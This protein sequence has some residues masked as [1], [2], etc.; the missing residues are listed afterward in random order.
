[1]F[2][3]HLTSRLLLGVAVSTLIL[4]SA[5]NVAMAEDYTN[6]TIS[7]VVQNEAGQA[8]AGATITV[9]NK[10]GTKRTIVTKV[11]GSYR[12]PALAIG[13][14]TATITKEGYDELNEQ[15]F[16]VT[17]G[18]S[19]QITFTLN[20]HNADMEEIFVVGTRQ[21][22][23]DFNT[24]TTGLTVSVDDLFEKTPIART[25]TAIALLAPGTT[26]G[27][28]AFG[29]LASIAGSSVAEN[30]YYIN[31]MNITNFRT[32]VGGSTLPFEFYDQIEVKTGGY[33]AEFGRSTGG[34]INAVTKSGSNEFHAGANVFWEG[35]AFSETRPDTYSN[36]NRFDERSNLNAN[37][38]LSGP[39]V[40]DKF[41]F[42]GMYNPRNNSQVDYTESRKF[43][44]K[45]NDPFWGLKL[46][47]IPIE[48]HHFEATFFSDDRSNTTESYKFNDLGK[49]IA[50]VDPQKDLGNLI[51]TQTDKLGG[52][53]KI[54]K[55]TGVITDWFTISALYGEN[56]YSRSSTSDTD[57]NPV[58]YSRPGFQGASSWRRLGNWSN[59]NVE[60]G[61]DLRKAYRVDA[62]L[63]F[64]ALGSHH[65]R[66]GWDREN[67][68]AI[69][70]SVNSGGVY[71]MY[72]TAGASNTQ[73][74]ADGQDYVRVREFRN[75]GTFNTI[76]SAVYAQD[77]W[78]VLDG[79]TLNA[80]IRNET[81]KN[82][83]GNGE[84]YIE[85]KNQIAWRLGFTWDP[86]GDGASRVYGNW[87]RY[88]LPIATNTSIRQA[89]AETYIQR[90]FPLDGLNPD[91]TPIYDAGAT[92]TFVEV[93][94]DGTISAPVEI[95][96]TNIKPMYQDEFI[97]G[98]EHDFQNGW[99]VGVRGI[100]RKLGRMIEDVAID[101]AVIKWAAENGYDDAQV[102]GT[103]GGFHQY[104][105]TNPGADMTVS[106]DK[107]GLTGL[108]SD[109]GQF[110]VA[111]LT[112]AQLGYPKGN[113]SYKAIELTFAREWD[114]LWSM[115]GSYTLSFSK[116]NTEG[117]VKSD[118]GQD[119]AGITTDFDQPGLVDGSFGYL[120]NDRRHKFKLWGAY[121]ATDWMTVGVNLSLTSPRK[122]G[123][124][125]FHPTDVFAQAYG[126]NS[127][128]CN[129]VLTPRAQSFSTGWIKKLDLSASIT[130]GF[131]DAIPGDVVLRVD[132]FNVFNT[133]GATDYNEIGEI[134][135]NNP[136]PNYAKPTSYQAPRSIR[137]SASY[138]F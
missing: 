32:F 122:Y 111:T 103:W 94:G 109:A 56:E 46:D 116:G 91:D 69:N 89:S 10:Q 22:G 42:F 65:V 47:F 117:S 13:K 36:A 130:P 95:L 119:D 100:Y 125:G 73:G 134:G 77:S 115:Q 49:D 74:F 19:G 4:S 7:G 67:L 132:V 108:T 27:D 107:E 58:I 15:K 38:Y 21:A 20:S 86:M 64:D 75:G 84:K 48:G 131:S 12:I 25:T 50:Q 53:N 31:G 138:K 76:Q 96:D 1:M 39:I 63:Y 60:T 90:Y 123:C 68:T 29:N 106:L 118:N 135:L 93:F 24:T 41:F 80:G 81:F 5:G 2:N 26:Q 72:G 114:G 98:Y 92:P 44:S 70:N 40:K 6:G 3:K 61:S 17:V 120:P 110:V 129:S 126:A 66:I 97:L 133:H 82:K 33:Q 52:T 121:Q 34:V 51:G 105:L 59:F 79:F 88:Y 113:R 35:N 57:S 136:N 55:Y 104:V 11:N 124:I 28:S 30:A 8:I 127:W 101:A 112:Q 137:F 87:G 62:D 37:F 54:F 78:Q 43:I 99:I 102:R 23:Y 128:Y 85:V 18:S 16:N 9:I 71:Y 83:N 45:Q 14:Y